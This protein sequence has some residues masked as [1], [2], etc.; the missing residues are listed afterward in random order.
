MKKHLLKPLLTLALVLLC[1]NVWGASTTIDVISEAGLTASQTLNATPYQVGEYPIFLTGTKGANNFP[2]LNYNSTKGVDLR[3][4]KGTTC[5]VT[6]TAGAG[7][8]LT[9]IEFMKDATTASTLSNITASEGTLTDN[10]W[11]GKTSSVTFT[12][13]NASSNFSEKIYIINL[14]Y[15][16]DGN[17]PTSIYIAGEATQTIYENGDVFNPAGLSVMAKYSSGDD[18]P[19]TTGITWSF[20]PETLTSATTTVSVTAQYGALTSAAKNVAVTVANV[21]KDALTPTKVSN[22]SSYGS[23]TYAGTY[24]SYA[25]F[26]TGGTSKLQLKSA[27]NVSGMVTTSSTSTIQKVSV[28]WESSTTSGRTLNVYGSNEAYTDPT[29]LYDTDKQGELLGTIVYGTSTELVIT[30]EYKYIGVRSNS[31]ALYLTD[32]T[33]NWAEPKTLSSLAV[34]SAPATTSY[35]LGDDLDA[36]GLVLT[37]TYSD[38]STEDFTY[39][40]AT[41]GDYTFTGYD[42]STTGS[43]TVTVTYRGQTATFGIEVVDATLT[44]IAVSGSLTKSEYVEGEEI[45]FAGLVATGSYSDGST[46]DITSDVTWAS[47]VTE[48]EL[49]MTSVKVTATYDG[50]TSAEKSCD[51]TVT[52]APCGITN[53]NKFF[54]TSYDGSVNGITEN[55]FTL[56]GTT[57]GVTA[58]VNNGSSTNAYI[59]NT[60]CRFYN[61]YTVTIQAPAGKVI[62]GITATKGGKTITALTADAGTL[63]YTTSALTWTGNSSTVVLS[64]TNTTSFG[65]IYF[66][67]GDT[68]ERTITEAGWATLFVD[69]PVTIPSG[70]TAYTAA[71]SAAGDGLDLTKI[72]S[73]SIPANTAVLLK[74]AAG[75]YEFAVA[76]SATP[77]TGNDLQGVKVATSQAVVSEANEGNTIYVLS[78][79]DGEVGFYKLNDTGTVN[80]YNA[81][82]AVSSS[83]TSLAIRLG[84]A[85]GIVLKEG[86]ST[87]S[88][89]DLLGRPVEN[90]AKG[91]YI[92]DGK[93]VFIK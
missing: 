42:M 4:Y 54:G 21:F 9:N 89:Y 77:V 71:V 43:Q 84:D 41:K 3:L 58:T 93:K 79:Q 17:A 85:T 82:V 78:Y 18:K 50:I 5:S 64:A 8:I 44:S 66:T 2:V 70:V 83:A 60:E 37:G 90:P 10:V 28:S 15:E 45:D 35:K 87:G 48:M 1:G 76:A 56:T 16:P 20:D 39:T 59:K 25:G 23:W 38:S 11:T 55:N 32:I 91:I 67:T 47:N 27:D 13:D 53:W 86:Q 80:A 30:G 7:N 92:K 88:Y 19:L 40:E 49:G 34:K 36:T 31:G 69:V 73:A 26:S 12:Y 24:A 14:T 72:E 46:N 57:K 68:F 61:G 74:G 6:F 75:T 29:D 81:Y 65:E 51:I 62:T 63:T 22:P 52:E 33:F